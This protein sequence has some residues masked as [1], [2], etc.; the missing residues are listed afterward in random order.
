[1]S[2]K[3]GSFSTHSSRLPERCERSNAAEDIGSSRQTRRAAEQ[4]IGHGRDLEQDVRAPKQQDR[5]RTEHVHEVER[6]REKGRIL[7]RIDHQIAE[8]EG[9]GGGHHGVERVSQEEFQPAPEQEFKIRHD[10]E[11][12]KDRAQKN[13]DGGRDRTEQIHRNRDKLPDRDDDF[14]QNV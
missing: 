10:K 12:D 9:H 4:V 1:A 11:R 7:Q 5:Q 2:L 8:N 3:P 13:G 14:N 6:K